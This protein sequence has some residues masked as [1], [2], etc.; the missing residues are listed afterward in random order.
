MTTMSGFE[1]FE[2][3][4]NVND[5]FIEE[6]AEMPN[7]E[8]EVINVSRRKRFSH[9]LNSGWGVAMICCL[10]AAAVMAGIIAAGRATGPVK[11]PVVTQTPETESNTAKE[12]EQIVTEPNFDADIVLTLDDK[13]I[14]LAFKESVIVSTS[15]DYGP[16]IEDIYTDIR[17]VEYVLFGGTQVLKRFKDASLQYADAT[18]TAGQATGIVKRVLA[19]HGWPM[20]YTGI[21]IEANFDGEG[22]VCRIED[23]GELIIRLN[24]NGDIYEFEYL[25][26]DLMRLCA[27]RSTPEEFAEICDIWGGPDNTE[28]YYSINE[29][30]LCFTY[31]DIISFPP[32]VETDEAGNP[33][34]DKH[35]IDHEHIFQH[36]K[37]VNIEPNVE[38]EV[39]DG[40]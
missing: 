36:M 3:M 19:D 6:A 14:P 1:I 39:P 10:V 29:G 31:E 8:L 13:T 25:S 37:I 20:L 30:Y 9:F 28:I 17:G 22:F 35:P 5:R 24:A 32:Y 12:T 40:E 11:P 7:P 21:R 26:S 27:E 4:T 34:P 2:K 38:T 15:S 33:L 18:V 23:F 16:I